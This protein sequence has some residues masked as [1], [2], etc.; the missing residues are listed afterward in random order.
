MSN[1][2]ESRPVNDQ[3]NRGRGGTTANRA[4]LIIHTVA[5]VAAAFLALWILLHLLGA[6]Q[7]N[8]FVQFVEGMADSLSWWARDIFT[9]DTE[10]LRVTLNYGLPAVIYLLVGHAI[11]GRVRRL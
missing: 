4:A 1:V 2:P 5:D 6:N 3:Y 7:A 8:V 10:G 11:A 9:M